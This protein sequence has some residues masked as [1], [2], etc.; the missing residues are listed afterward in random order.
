MSLYAI[1]TTLCD[2]F[3]E[4]GTTLRSF[5]AG[6]AAVSS[7]TDFTLE[8]ECLLEGLLSRAWQAW[9][10]FCRGCLVESCM[11]TVNGAGAAVAGH[12]FAMSAD[13]VSAAAIR[14]KQT[15][16][17]PAWGSTNSVLRLEPTWGDV[18]VLNTI[19]P[20]MQPSN[21][22][23]LLAAFSAAHKSAKA[24]QIIRNA[25]AHHN[26]QTLAEV[27]AIRSAYIVFPITR[28]I[29]ALFW[30]EP[31]TRDFLV[32]QAVEDLRDVSLAAIS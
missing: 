15:L 29:H 6:K 8:D 27:Q 30:V 31:A 25:A 4:L 2:E 24:L 23:Q 13:H 28:A 20:R 5:A 32:L 11:G 21:Q 10:G 16:K 22:G 18:D 1:W 7:S 26:H 9:G 3:D 19:I 17:P 12:P 14:S